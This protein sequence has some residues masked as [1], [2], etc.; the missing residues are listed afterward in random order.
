MAN[1]LANIRKNAKGLKNSRV[2]ALD[3]RHL[4]VEKKA[5]KSIKSA[6]KINGNLFID[7]VIAN[8]IHIM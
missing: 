2:G 1:E 4:E 8:L 3:G 7:G 5:L 6:L